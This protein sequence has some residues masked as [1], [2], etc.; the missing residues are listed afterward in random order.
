MESLN[1]PQKSDKIEVTDKGFLV[2]SNCRAKIRGVRVTPG[3]VATG[4]EVRCRV[5]K[6]T[7]IVDIASGQSF[8]RAS[9]HD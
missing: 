2:C 1:L 5:C 8:K 9:A 7:F 3:T 6:T 4:L